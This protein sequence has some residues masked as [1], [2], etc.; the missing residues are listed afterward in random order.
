MIWSLSGKDTVPPDG[1]EATVALAFVYET[2]TIVHL[3]GHRE[4]AVEPGVSRIQGHDNR[5]AHGETVSA[6]G[7]RRRRPGMGF[8]RHRIRRGV[9]EG[10]HALGLASRWARTARHGQVCTE[11]PGSAWATVVGTACATGRSADAGFTVQVP[12]RWGP[13]ACVVRIRGASEGETRWSSGTRRA[14]RLAATS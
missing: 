11:P 8:G 13:V 3:R 6:D 4:R 5:I 10:R 14:S 9:D 12:P 2:V 1:V 7:Q